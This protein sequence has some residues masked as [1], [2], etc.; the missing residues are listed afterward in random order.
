MIADSPEPPTP[1]S[2][3]PLLVTWRKGEPILRCHDSRFGGNEYNPSEHG[4]GRFRPL[5]TDDEFVPV[6]YGADVFE[7]ALAE[8]VF[9]DVLAGTPEQ[10]VF[11][12]RFRTWVRST[13]APNRD[14]RLV[15]LF[16]FGLRRL[17]LERR[18]LIETGHEAYPYTARWALALYGHPEQPDGIVWMSRL[19]DEAHSLMLFGTR[20]GRVEL[21]V[22]DVPLALGAEVGLRTIS[23]LAAEA[24]ITVVDDS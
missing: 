11:V 9:H 24:D 14:L 4:S 6:L 23:L 13:I 1:G 10:R 12:S 19:Y 16:G 5:R 17:G 22:V 3:N 2:L 20:V 15:Q 8:S 7:G 18:H 21:D